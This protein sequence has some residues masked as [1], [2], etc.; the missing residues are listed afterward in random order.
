MLQS[1]SCRVDSGFRHHL[2]W[3]TGA[4]AV[5]VRSLALLGNR[6]ILPVPITLSSM[7][8]QVYALP[9]FIV[10]C[11][12][13]LG[14]RAGFFLPTFTA[15]SSKDRSAHHSVLLTSLHGQVYLIFIVGKSL[16][17]STRMCGDNGCNSPP[18]HRPSYRSRPCFTS[19]FYS[20]KSPS[21][22]SP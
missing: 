21:A 9:H 3:S 15:E 1:L 20:G 5:S 22:V 11:Q 2:I 6:R 8:F 10:Y 18:E 12:P 17:P 13:L 16:L 7:Q 19:L 14:C 4:A